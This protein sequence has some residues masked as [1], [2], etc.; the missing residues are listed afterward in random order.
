VWAA[1]GLAV[2]LLSGVGRP[3]AAA[4]DEPALDRDTPKLRFEALPYAWV[5]GVHGSVAVQD[6]TVRVDVGPV[7]VLELLFDGNAFAA[8]GYFALSY[9]RFDVF[10]DSWGGYAETS[11]AQSIPTQLCCTL[12]I[13]AKDKMKFALTDVGL[14]Y[15][16]LRSSL[17]ERSRPVT[18]GLWAGAR[19]VYLSNELDAKIGVVQGAKR[20]ANVRDSLAWADP[21]I[22]VRRSVPVL[23]DVALDFRSDIGGF[24]A[25]SDLTWGLL[26]DVRLWLP[27]KPF[28]LAPYLVL[29][30][31]L[32][33]FDRSPGAAN[34][35]L[36]LRGPVLGTGF[37]FR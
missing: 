24:G 8:A 37:V 18:L 21:L 30:Y 9:D 7:D 17:T 28:D 20:S 13:G 32:V 6:T 27:W 5:L 12:T 22:G 31:R 15:E 3:C 35:D 29:G 26:G 11:V 36:Q 33:A 16:L 1:L 14:G 23:E 4:A 19:T 25:S 10:V 2:V 34:V